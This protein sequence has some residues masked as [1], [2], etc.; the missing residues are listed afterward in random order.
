MNAAGTARLALA[1]G[2]VR[3]DGKNEDVLLAGN[4]RQPS[5][6]VELLHSHVL[7]PPKV[8]SNPTRVLYPKA[9]SEGKKKTGKLN[10]TY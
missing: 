7:Y 3:G 8:P 10:V 5:F 2:G 1:E 9:L 6:I 4:E